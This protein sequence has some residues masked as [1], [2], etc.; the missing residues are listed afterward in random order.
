[1]SSPL[2]YSEFA[3]D[4][5]MQE[6]LGEFCN[7]L[8]DTICRLQQA[9]ELRD[10]T[11]IQRIAHQMKG[12]GAGYGFESLSKIGAELES[13]AKFGEWSPTLHERADE[14]IRQCRLARP[15]SPVGV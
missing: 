2:L 13:V 9:F 3:D 4:P 10:M 6:I 12:A 5:D 14:F 11:A 8:P 7:R 1:M 15:T